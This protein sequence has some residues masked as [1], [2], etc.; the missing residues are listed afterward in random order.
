MAGFACVDTLFYLCTEVIFFAFAYVNIYVS[1]EQILS[2]RKISNYF[3]REMNKIIDETEGK[4]E[5]QISQEN[6]ARLKLSS[7]PCYCLFVPL[8]R[9]QREKLSPVTVELVQ[10]L[11]HMNCSWNMLHALPFFSS[12]I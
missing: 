10:T 8:R 1:L 11:A 5:K 12:F 7:V 9:Q 6:D 4:T 3:Q 2:R